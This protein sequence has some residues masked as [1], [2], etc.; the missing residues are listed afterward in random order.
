MFEPTK[1]LSDW[2]NEVSPTFTWGWPHLKLIQERLEDQARGEVKNLMVLCPPQHG[3]SELVTVRY[4]VWRLE[5]DPRLR[6]IVSAYNQT[7]V[8]KLARKIRRIAL[9][10]GCFRFAS[11][12]LAASEW[13]LVAGGGLLAVGIGGGVT[14]NPAELAIIDDPIKGREDAESEIQ[15]EKVWEWYVDELSTRIQQDGQKLLVL[16][17]WH[18]DDLRGRILNS[19]EAKHWTVVRLPA[20]SEGEGDPLGRPEGTPLC[21]E[22]RSLEWLLDQKALGERSFQA[23]YQCNPTPREGSFFQ[24]GRLLEN[25]RGEVPSIVRWSRA[26]DLAASKGNGDFSVGVLMGLDGQGRFW[27]VDVTRGQWSPDERNER[28]RQTA[29]VDGESVS[30]RLPQD[31]GQAGK[32][33]AQA[34]IRMLAGYSVKAISVSGDKQVRADPLAAQLNAGNVLLLRAPWNAAFIEELRQFPSGRHDDAVDA[35]ADAFNELTA[36]SPPVMPTYRPPQSEAMGYVG[37]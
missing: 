30:I 9:A 11:D 33:Q 5:F 15:R 34:L 4:P 6:V 18:E 2:L 13:E 19:P 10:R 16:T 31:P 26:W 7:Y 28:M 37:R 32:E 17:P 23:L 24:V 27:I 29:R 1:P 21:A 12:R 3:K 8:D 36:G 35:A 22:R 25:L 14:G 20:I